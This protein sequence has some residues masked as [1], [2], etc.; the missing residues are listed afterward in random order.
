MAINDKRLN[1]V[2]IGAGPLYDELVSLASRLGVHKQIHFAGFQSNPYEWFAAADYFV[3]SSRVEGFPNVVLEALACGT[4]VVATP[5]PGGIKE[6]M[7][8]PDY[9]WLACDTSVAALADTLRRALAGS[10]PTPS[11]EDLQTRF[12]VEQIVARYEA[13]F[14]S[15]ANLPPAAAG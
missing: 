9:G 8:R 6:I 4:P 11:L 3:L 7:T 5:C 10:R 1:L 2:I 13:L 14:R 15:L 12:G